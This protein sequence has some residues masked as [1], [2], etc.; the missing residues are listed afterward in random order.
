M[1]E[2]EAGLDKVAGHALTSVFDAFS[3][4]GSLRTYLADQA[5]HPVDARK[6]KRIDLARE[7]AQGPQYQGTLTHANR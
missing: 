7:R 2:L 4:N 1:P 5:R 6:Q 3:P